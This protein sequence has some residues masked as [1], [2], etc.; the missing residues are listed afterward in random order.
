MP[1]PS[2]PSSP[3][4][5]GLSSLPP[6]PAEIERMGEAFGRLAPAF[7]AFT[8]GHANPPFRA[9]APGPGWGPAQ[10]IPDQGAGLEPTLDELGA[11]LEHAGRISAPGF[12]GFITTGSA[13]VPAAAAGA[14]A[15]AGGQ[16]YMHH[17]FNALE[18]TSLRWLAD[19][20]G[21]PEG[22]AGVYS[23]GG[24]TANLVALGAAR[25]A[26]VE[27]LGIDAAEDGQPA[28][29]RGRIHA[30]ALAHRTV[31]RAAAV[32]GLGRRAVIAH[33]VDGDGRVRLDELE[34]A[35]EADARDGIT[36]VAIIALAGSTDTGS[37]DRIDRLAALARRYGTWLHVDGAYGLTANADPML[38]G[39]FAGVEEADS[40][41]VD[42]H[43]WLATG[44]GIGATFV[45]DEGVLTRAFA[46][47]DA[48]YLEGSMQGAPDTAVSQFDGFGGPWA[49][50]GVELSSP[51]RGVIVWAT[52]REIGR[53]GVV[54]RIRRHTG[55]AR[56]T[57]E[58]ARS[59][60]RLE[61]LMEPQLSVVCFRYLPAGT[62]AGDQDDAI[63]EANRRILGRLRT[64]TGLVPSSTVV[65]GRLAIRPCFI[66]PR[67]TA[68][69]VDGLVD[70]VLRFGAEDDARAR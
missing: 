65:D 67:T 66:N 33:A 43:K 34:A 21:L 18:H 37:V 31:H 48:A 17:S 23:S 50:Q 15:V 14:V 11:L 9:F 64:E 69:E 5:P 60:P 19:I 3:P 62:A 30:S 16:R 24:S 68:A 38:A 25:Q 1:L 55:F 46:E 10:P 22:V 39:L 8:A 27:R 2:S 41:I 63:D 4:V 6:E 44:V 20:S 26:A 36:P 7:D 12:T 47:G 57:A 40:W 32:L 29:F 56:H 61:L 42:P 52:L 13:T 53:A 49:D 58:R 51:A 45:R 70:A 28:G 35:L 54:D 59:E